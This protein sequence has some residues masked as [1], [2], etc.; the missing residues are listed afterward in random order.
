M[1]R[2]AR[3]ARA[4][5]LAA[6]VEAAAAAVGDL[7][8]NV[9]LDRWMHVPGP[10]VWSI[11]KEAEHLSEAAVYHQWIVKLTIGERVGSRRPTIERS[12]MTTDLSP[13]KAIDLL[14][15]RANEGAALVRALSEE[16]LDLPTRPP[17]AGDERLAATIERVLIGHYR[18]HLDAIATHL[19]GGPPRLTHVALPMQ[20][21]RP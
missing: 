7:L 14:L 16:Q 15:D 4:A 11:G 13:R 8:A 20:C 9:P 17:R 3:S 21:K 5:A 12:R 10:G 1:E 6:D 2:P 19:R 18:V